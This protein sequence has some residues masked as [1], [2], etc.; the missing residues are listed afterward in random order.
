MN[1]LPFNL[2]IIITVCVIIPSIITIKLRISLYKYLLKIDKQ[3]RGL[4]DDTQWQKPKIVEQLEEKYKKAGQ[5]LEQVNTI[6]LIEQLYSQEK[7]NG[8]FCEQIDYLCRILPNLL[9]A[10]GLL[11]TFLGMT[12]NLTDLSQVLQTTNAT[13]I[14]DLI[15]QLQQP[16]TGMGIAFVTSLIGLFFSVVLTFIN[17]YFNTNLAK[18]N[19]FNSL[20]NYLDNIYQTTIEGNTRLDKAVNRMVDTQEEFLTRFHINVTELLASSL[21]EIA[22]QINEGNKEARELATVV[23]EQ[24]KD[25][26]GTISNA[27]NQ[28]QKAMEKATKLS[29]SADSFQKSAD[30][31][32]TIVTAL[33]NTQ[34]QFSQA[35]N[36]LN[37]STESMTNAVDEM[38]N[39]SQ[40][41][42]ELT[43]N[44]K[45]LNESSFSVLTLQGKNQ[46]SLAVII[47]EISKVTTGFNSILDKFQIIE[48]KI[49]N[50]TDNL[51]NIPKEFKLLTTSITQH[52]EG[53]N[54]GIKSLG[55]DLSQIVVVQ[56]NG[57][58]ENLHSLGGKLDNHREYLQVIPTG[59]QQLTSS[60]T[61]QTEGINLGIEST[62]D[63]LSKIFVVQT[64]SILD[65]LRTLQGKLDNHSQ[66][67]QIIP[68]EFK[69]YSQGMNLGI[70]SVGNNLSKT[71]GLNI[72]SVLDNLQSLQG[73]LDNHTEHLRV[74]PTEFK[75]YSQGMNLG[76]KSVGANLSKTV[77]IIDQMQNSGREINLKLEEILNKI[78]SVVNNTSQ[79]QPEKPQQS[80]KTRE[81]Y[82][83]E[84]QQAIIAFNQNKNEEALIILDLLIKDFPSNAKLHLLRGQ[85]FQK[86]DRNSMAEQCYKLVLDLT[87]DPQLIE[88][89]NIGL[90]G[91]ENTE[92]DPEIERMRRIGDDDY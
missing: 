6:P 7:V 4:I 44:L 38:R 73:K 28:F 53:M 31:L 64:N 74:I 84:Y 45:T 11:G 82:A 42:T 30:N 46:E 36:I 58:L 20:E 76:I 89:A 55:D 62:G 15:Q 3:I 59:L 91:L 85:I 21:G 61:Q 10:F 33:A 75:Q 56:T 34:K 87:N 78:P 17:F 92:V 8:I 24:F 19:L 23:Y 65:N 12:I 27:A 49:E 41:L 86:I 16:L 68:T 90:S 70:E 52:T 22:T 69:Q 13:N 50:H 40:L 37:N 43:S 88:Y 9:L 51:E 66:L 63:N 54:L 5:Q 26:S 32:V 77:E 83:Q 47:P 2:F 35:T 71:V 60:I 25:A 14:N 48:E 18:H 67:L 39:S 79:N 1:F 57:I 81:E 72:K 29:Q 80:I